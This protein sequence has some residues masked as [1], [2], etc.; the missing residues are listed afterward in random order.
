M[1]VTSAATAVALT[2][3]QSVR[4]ADT[5]PII[6]V[7]GSAAHV[8]ALQETDG[9]HGNNNNNNKR[10]RL[11]NATDTSHFSHTYDV[12]DFKNFSVSER[13]IQTLTLQGTASSDKQKRS[14]GALS[15]P[16]N[17][18]ADNPPPSLASSSNTTGIDPIKS[19]HIVSEVVTNTSFAQSEVPRYWESGKLKLG[20]VSSPAQHD[21]L[22]ATTAAAGASPATPST[23][24]MK[25]SQSPASSLP[26]SSSVASSSTAS[27]LSDSVAES[28][29]NS[30]EDE[31]EYEPPPPPPPSPT[32][33][34]KPEPAKI[35]PAVSHSAPTTNYGPGEKQNE[36]TSELEKAIFV[37]AKPTRL[38]TNPTQYDSGTLNVDYTPETTKPKLYT[39]Q[40][41]QTTNILQQDKTVLTTKLYDKIVV[42]TKLIHSTEKL[43]T[44]VKPTP[45]TRQQ[46]QKEQPEKEPTPVPG[47][48]NN[49][50]NNSNDKS[51]HTTKTPPHHDKAPA[52]GPWKGKSAYA[53]HSPTPA[54]ASPSGHH[55][56]K[57]FTGFVQHVWLPNSTPRPASKS[58]PSE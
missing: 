31:D 53:T 18:T 14:D 13:G 54:G 46:P 16:V 42:T 57:H 49:K 47:K 58:S 25:P 15:S 21:G 30:L 9:N 26:T 2:L 44:T 3:L 43:F 27:V 19:K 11:S 56:A 35:P 29:Q 1:L 45:T 7:S 40:P 23:D 20:N 17:N 37:E 41:T 28:S 52:P 24:T 51:P 12:S 36:S 50:T 8:T 6:P 39:V 34:T 33:E 48:T 38:G 4:I 22:S 5:V 55:V 10:D 32:S